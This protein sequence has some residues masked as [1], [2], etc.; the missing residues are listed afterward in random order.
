MAKLKYREGD[1]FAVPLRAGGFGIGLI[2]R[3]NHSGIL[4]GYFFGP[5]RAGV[6]SLKEVQNQRPSDA[7]L[8]GRFGHLGIVQGQWPIF[9][10]LEGWERSAWPMPVFLRRE[11]LTGR[12]LNV[13]YSDDD[14]GRVV[15]EESI[16]VSFVIQPKDG[17]M[18]AGFVEKVLTTTLGGSSAAAGY[19]T[20][21]AE[22]LED[23][24]LQSEALTDW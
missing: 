5:R 21:S 23:P 17:L 9:G 4:L 13:F 2:A 22:T 1:W 12:A 11:E 8:V 24:D 6:P 16:Q 14:P 20:L 7:C 10:R 15:R 19:I 3:A 18:G